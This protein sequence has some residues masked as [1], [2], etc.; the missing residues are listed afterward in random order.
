MSKPYTLTL[1]GPDGKTVWSR[2]VDEKH[3]KMVAEFLQ[4]NL[5]LI[6]AARGVMDTVKGMESIMQGLGSVGAIAGP[7]RKRGKR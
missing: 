5:G 6:L 2:E 7:K 4:N 3:V 1:T